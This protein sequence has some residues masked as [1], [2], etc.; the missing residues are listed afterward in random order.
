[1]LS[2]KNKRWL[3]TFS[4][5]F[6][7]RSEVKLSFRTVVWVWWFSLWHPHQSN[8]L[9]KFTLNAFTFISA[10]ISDGGTSMFLWHLPVV[11]LVYW[12]WKPTSV[13]SACNDG[14]FSKSRQRCCGAEAPE[15][16]APC[17]CH[18]WSNDKNKLNLWTGES[19]LDVRHR[20]NHLWSWSLWLT[21]R[22]DLDSVGS[23]IPR[24]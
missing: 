22:T 2:W 23:A 5:M 6:T 13:C 12:A 9:C 16:W 19:E 10:D 20:E 17:C 11:W 7:E 3:L 8:F 15:S 24:N 4:V 21:G 18:H 14:T 1:M